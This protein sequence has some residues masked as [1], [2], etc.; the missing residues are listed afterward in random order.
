MQDR[1]ERRQGLDQGF[2][3]LAQALAVLGRDRHRL[4]QAERP[5]LGG[6]GIAGLAFG[7]VDHQAQRLVMAAQP[8]GEMTVQRRQPGAGVGHHQHQIRLAQHGLGAGLHAGFEAL[9]VGVL[10]ARGVDHAE[11]RRAQPA[12]ALAPVARDPRAVVDQGRPAPDEAV[13]QG[14]FAHIGAADNG[15]GDC[16]GAA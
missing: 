14:R 8:V 1:I 3:E 11:L 16:H 4:A 5:G 6:A 10:Q 12:G 13:E 7:L 2:V 9:G 15:N